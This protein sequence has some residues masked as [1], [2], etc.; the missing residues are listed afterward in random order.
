M[1][2]RKKLADI[3]LNSDREKLGRVWDSTKAADDLKPLPSGEYRCTIASG[4]LFTA[5]KGTLGYKLKLVVLKGEHA[6]RL[7]WHDVWLSELALPMAKRDLG[8]LGI[9]SLEQ[10][11]RPLPEGIVVAAKV[12]LRKG[13]DG[14]EF[15]KVTRLDVVGIETPEP[16][17]FAPAE[18]REGEATTDAAGFN[19]ATGQQ[20]GVKTP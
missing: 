7:I 14:A 3:L 15:N 12:A 1:N 2:A 8:K 18:H 11:E 20:N 19:W 4:E 5:K 6:D 10:L 17:P 9:T 13:D 16:E